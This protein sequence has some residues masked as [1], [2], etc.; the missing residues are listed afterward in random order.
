MLFL[1]KGYSQ[2][3][4]QEIVRQAQVKQPDIEGELA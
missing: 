1:E 2:E 4:I 3:V